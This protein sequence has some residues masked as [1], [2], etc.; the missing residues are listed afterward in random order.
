MSVNTGQANVASTLSVRQW[1][2][3]QWLSSECEWNNLLARSSADALFLS[4]QWLTHWWE[5][6]AQKLKLDAEI[7]AFYRGS[8][9]VGIA[10][11]YRALV[12][13]GGVARVHSVQFIGHTW[14]NPAPLISEYLDVIAARND[15]DSVRNEC[16][17]ALLER[18]TWNELAI[19]FTAV[20]REW[21][22]A[23]SRQ[24]P[25]RGHYARELDRAVSYQADLGQGFASYL[26]DLGQ[27]TRR[28]IWNLRRRLADEYGD[29]QLES[30]A[31]ENIDSGFTDLNRLHQS[32]WSKPA[33]EGER[34]EFHKTFAAQSAKR[35]ELA[36]TRLRVG[37][38]VVSVLYDICRGARQYNIKMGFDP[39][40]STRLS[41]GLIHFGYAMEAAAERGVM[42]YDF[43]A[44]PGLSY[45]FKRNLGQIRRELCG[46][47]MLR[48]RFLPTV[49]RW[50][51]RL[52]S[53]E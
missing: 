34:L 41:L 17:R 43:L 44:G 31:L 36:F 20:G 19:G 35:G 16:L 5:Y 9:L 37:G 18:P 4:W 50:R 24:A 12:V 53:P 21:R 42:Q 49:Y 26:K 45:D 40:F 27:S 47:Q 52:R 14:R 2:L 32:R 39:G 13:R 22:E 23:F 48:G 46:V 8:E 1:S 33:F 38:V 11:L 7:L 6:Y 25:S 28:S 30:L 15:L 29:V 3:E 51:D 10:P